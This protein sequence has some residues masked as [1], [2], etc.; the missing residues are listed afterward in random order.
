MKQAHLFI[1]E[2]GTR[3]PDDATQNIYTLCGTF[4]DDEHLNDAIE[5]F[6]RLKFVAF[7]DTELELKSNWMRI[8]EE[9]QVRY[10]V[11]YS[12]TDS[13]FRAFCEHL[14]K[15][16]H[17]LPVRLVAASVNKMELKKRYKNPFYPNPLAY[18]LLVQRIANICHDE[19]YKCQVVFDDFP[20]GKTAAGHR[21]KEL[22]ISKHDAL[23]QG[24]YS[25]LTKKWDKPMN[26]KCL[27]DEIKFIRSRDEPII[28]IS[29]L[30]AYNISRQSSKYWSQQIGGKGPFYYWGYR[31]IRNLIHRNPENRN[32]IFGYGIVCFPQ[33]E[34]N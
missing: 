13:R 10:L 2:S 1:D 9:R 14:Y 12:Y 23:K 21:W 34:I 33:R 28:Q 32:Q 5:D 27:S 25:A 19:E 4:I 24:K 29:D 20:E 8:D 6:R 22:L 16:M 18:E 15:W 3:E 26:Y 31:Q 7:A 30:C 11:P 17:I